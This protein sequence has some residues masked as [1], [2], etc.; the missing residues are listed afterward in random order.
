MF[1]T[2]V[3]TAYHCPMHIAPQFTAPVKIL[4][5]SFND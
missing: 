4:A 5:R 3:K 1:Q 2:P